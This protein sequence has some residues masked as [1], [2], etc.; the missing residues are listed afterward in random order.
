[1]RKHRRQPV[2]RGCVSMAIAMF[3][4]GA[5]PL[6]A[7]ES[8]A[9]LLA[10]AT[11]AYRSGR[12]DEVILRTDAC[13]AGRTS[14]EERQR[15]YTLRT[16][17]F[18]ALDQLKEAEGSASALLQANPE[19]APA[20]DDSERFRTLVLRIKQEL[21]RD[22][23]SGVSKMNESLLEAPATVI[24]V[25]ADQI[26]RRGYQ[27]IEMVL[28]DLPGFDV[29]KT[30]GQSYANV[31]QRG[32]RSDA[33]NRTLFMVDGIEQ[34]DL[35]SNIAYISRQYPLSN[36]ERIEVVYGPA[37]TMYGPN[38]FLGVINV[39]T[40]DP[41]DI[42]GQGKTFGSDLHVGGGIWN[43][44]YVDATVG[45]RLR[46]AAFSITGR[47]F[48]SDEWD[49]S[50][51]Q[52]W[53]YIY[54]ASG[55]SET[56]NRYEKKFGPYS[57]L[58]PGVDVVSLTR[59]LDRPA[60]GGVNGTAL[61]YSDLTD[62]WMLSGKLK[63]KDFVF[64][65]QMWQ[66][67]EGAASSSTKWAEPGARN[68]NIWV[69]FQMAV[70]ARYSTALSGNVR[71]TY[72]GQGKVHKLQPQSSAFLLHSY[73]TGPFAVGDLLDGFNLKKNPPQAFWQQTYLAQSSN[74]VRNEMD[75]A[76]QMR[77]NLNMIGG[78]DLRNGSI[79][80]DY[81]KSTNCPPAKVD[82]IAIP[83]NIDPARVLDFS[84]HLS[85][86]ELEEWFRLYP[87][88]SERAPTFLSVTDDAGRARCDPQ[89]GAIGPPTEGGPHFAVQE[90]G[91]FAQASYRPVRNVKIVA[92]WRV[93]NGRID[94]NRGYGTVA[95]PRFA[96]V[97]SPGNIVVKTVFAEAFKDPANLERFSIVPGVRDKAPSSLRP[98][99]ARN[100]ELA[101]GRQATA[102][103][104][105]VS[106]YRSRYTDVIGVTELTAYEQLNSDAY[107]R[108]SDKFAEQWYFT[109]CLLSEC[110][111]KALMQLPDPKARRI[112]T[113]KF[114]TTP[115]RAL[116]F[117]NL[118]TLNVWGAQANASWRHG[119][120]ELF[121]NYSYARPKAATGATQVRVGDIARHR[122][123]VGVA[124]EWHKL[125]VN[126]R[127]NVV[128]T[129]PTINSGGIQTG[130]FAFLA[131]QKNRE[132]YA[133]PL[134]SLSSPLLKTDGYAVANA[135]ATYALRPGF[136]VQ[137][138]VE[139]LFNTAYDDPGVQTA[140]NI[141]FAARVPQP[142]RALFVGLLTHF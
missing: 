105:D 42:V 141:R 40:R 50:R 94:L 2:R 113:E 10:D 96:L 84:L 21:A 99:R 41:D 13:L 23:V 12:F 92:G 33:T 79:Q 64:G 91:A 115:A 24:V 74:Q 102:Y 22:A 130:V 119:G 135:A 123:T 103:S 37:S 11:D 133:D 109:D 25:T 104:A 38:A 81:S 111:V 54:D 71:L 52:E 57:F 131:T 49:L 100:F 65:T 16:N 67:R 142:G 138:V 86:A 101:V 3:A 112:V 97:Y 36:I 1:M 125:D 56:K 75:V 68:G 137:A 116:S 93:D 14:S 127:L 82:D 128:G 63:V 35:F 120:I 134:E 87:R 132:L 7:Q 106:V 108:F 17:V 73:V 59:Q 48:R 15:L 27:D 72:F 95:T 5:S 78:V 28:H 66:T 53:N 140:D 126:V 90:L 61:G 43:T 124:R 30:N 20:V 117:A 118:G 34:N 18:L 121:G 136:S 114:V 83:D 31:Y 55:A 8:C 107:Y 129:R 45:G 26:R 46:G 70:Y 58:F 80:I 139:N 62:D 122:A 29:S 76:Y 32:Y 6:H 85:D 9:R 4:L 51:H 47:L 77:D 69:P 89:R 110:F 44:K 39:V 19:F 98:E 60:L 88:F